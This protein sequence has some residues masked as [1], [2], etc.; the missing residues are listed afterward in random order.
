[1]R[2]RVGV[3]DFVGV[4]VLLGVIDGVLEGVCVVVPER[5]GVCVGLTEIVEVLEG[6]PVGLTVDVWLRE[7]EG[8]FDGVCE[9]VGVPV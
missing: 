1:V 7:I 6:V 4:C 3:G 8:V 5:L 2:V 9:R